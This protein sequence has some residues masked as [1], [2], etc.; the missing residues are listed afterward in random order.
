MGRPEDKLRDRPIARHSA[1]SLDDRK[2][3][4]VARV[5][6]APALAWA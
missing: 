5:A 4:G 1:D 3:K 6:V 2:E